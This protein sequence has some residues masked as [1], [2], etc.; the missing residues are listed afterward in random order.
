MSRCTAWVGDKYIGEVISPFRTLQ[1]QKMVEQFPFF[2]S[3][4]Q[5]KADFVKKKADRNWGTCAVCM[6][7]HFYSVKLFK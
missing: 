5:K 6:M 2:Q 7:G 3:L 4:P 1:R